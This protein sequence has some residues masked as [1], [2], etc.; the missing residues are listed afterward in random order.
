MEG[1]SKKKPLRLE[2][3]EDIELDAGQGFLAM[4]KFLMAYYERAKGTA[5][6][7]EVL[8]DV[9]IETDRMSSDPAAL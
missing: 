4:G 6:L 7:A 9:Q 2:N 5:H 3:V 1:V 8:S